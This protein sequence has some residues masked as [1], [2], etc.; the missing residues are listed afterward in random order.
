[1]I[2]NLLGQLRADD[3]GTQ[4]DDLGVIALAGPF[5]AK[6][7]VG[8]GS[9]HTSHLVS[10]DGHADAGAANQNATL[11]L[12]SSHIFS[13]HHR[14]IRVIHRLGRVTPIV[15]HLNSLCSQMLLD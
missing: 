2:D 6:R 12:M 10:S 11:N 13:Q 7:I 15:F 1:M 5:G 8:L 14:H 9:I 4:R 3:A